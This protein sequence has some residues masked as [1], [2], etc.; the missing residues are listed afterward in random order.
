MMEH[1]LDGVA[2]IA[3]TFMVAWFGAWL[4]KIDDR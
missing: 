1:F 3:V 2:V 4:Q